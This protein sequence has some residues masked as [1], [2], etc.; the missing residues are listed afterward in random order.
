MDVVTILIW[1]DVAMFLSTL[2]MFYQ[3]QTYLRISSSC[4]GVAHKG[5]SR[6]HQLPLCWALLATPAKRHSALL[7]FYVILKTCPSHFHILIIRMM[8]VYS[9]FIDTYKFQCHNV[10]GN[11]AALGLI[12]WLYETLS[13][14]MHVSTWQSCSVLSIDAIY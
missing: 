9:W 5:R 11:Y 10:L 7:P 6:S 12:R 4:P 3:L 2:T 13:E 14:H 8:H 1:K